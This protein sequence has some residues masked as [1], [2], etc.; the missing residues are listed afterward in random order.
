MKQKRIGILALQGSFAEH[1]AVLEKMGLDYTFVRSVSDLEV[2]THLIVPGGESTAIEKLMRHNHLW[3][4]VV[5]RIEA[6]ALSVFGTCAGAILCQ[7]WGMDIE[8]DRNAYGS[9]QDSFIEKLDSAHFLDLE[10]VFI[11]AP[12]LTGHQKKLKVLVTLDNEPV[13]VEQKPFLVATFHPELNDRFDIYQ[14][15]L[16]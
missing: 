14:Y 16:S 11:R 5:S 12:R 6:G 10:G 3:E 9:Q 15:F 1:G 13:M 7:K 2:L 8:I 4:A